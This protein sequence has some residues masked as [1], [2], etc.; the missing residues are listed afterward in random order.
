M[1]EGA[2]GPVGKTF[3]CKS[4]LDVF[5]LE[6]RYKRTVLRKPCGMDNQCMERK[7]ER[8]DVKAST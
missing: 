8:R 7:L 1:F 5:D 6:D 4:C 3:R 2:A